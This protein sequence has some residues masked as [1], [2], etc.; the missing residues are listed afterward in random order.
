MHAKHVQQFS[1]TIHTL[2]HDRTGKES[3]GMLKLTTPSLRIADEFVLHDSIAESFFG[4][5][6]GIIN[7][8]L[9]KIWEGG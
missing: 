8:C 2:L 9:A 4:N 6:H 7:A 5:T 1:T 3:L